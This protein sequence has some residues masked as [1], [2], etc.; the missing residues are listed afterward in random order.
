[1]EQY[2]TRDEIVRRALA[3]MGMVSN[4]SQAPLVA[5]EFQE[6][7]RAAALAVYAEHEWG[8]LKREQRVN[9]GIDQTVVDYP[10]DSTAG[11]LIS[12]S[13][14]DGQR[15]IALVERFIP[16]SM[17][18]DPL[19]EE[20]EPASVAGRGRPC[21]FEKRGQIFIAPRPDQAY[22]LK[23]IHNQ[24]SDLPTGT[25]VS[26]VDAELISLRMMA[27]KRYDM[28]DETLGARLDQK[29]DDRALAIGRKS[30][31]AHAVRRNSGYRE[32]CNAR[33]GNVGYVPNSGQWPAVMPAE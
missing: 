28:G 23:I 12:V 21:Y 29:Y 13:V 15:Y 2:L 3:R 14:W 31:S 24:P 8:T 7:A 9:I 22:E 1:V 30:S 16:A 19:V 6:L 27:D 32:R 18:Q 26:V 33:L 10:D 5:A 17:T 11:D 4:A 25:S 20:G